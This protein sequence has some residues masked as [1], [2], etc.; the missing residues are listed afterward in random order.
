MTNT[1]A[2]SMSAAV[3]PASAAPLLYELQPTRP[4]PSIDKAK[5]VKHVL[6]S[7]RALRIFNRCTHVA[8]K[9]LG[10]SFLS[11]LMLGGA[12]IMIP[13]SS[14]GVV[15]VVLSVLLQLA[16]ICTALLV[17]R[18]DMV[19]LLT[20]TYE[21]WYLTVAN[22]F[23]CTLV[24][25]SL[26]DARWLVIF[27]VGLAFQFVLLIDANGR[28]TKAVIWATSLGALLNMSYVFCSMFGYL[29]NLE[30]LTLFQYKQRKL[31]A[32]EALLNVLGTLW[33]LMVRNAYRKHQ[34]SR[35]TVKT[36]PHTERVTCIMY[37]C[38]HSMR[39]VS[40]STRTLQ[41]CR[42]SPPVPDVAVTSTICSRSPLSRST[43]QLEFAHIQ[44]HFAEANVSSHPWLGS[45][46]RPLA[47][48]NWLSASSASV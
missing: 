23:V 39:P 7:P 36:S 12:S 14:T 8:G 45:C 31:Q 17:L 15:L 48:F 35:T 2:N 18:F 24:S 41:Q 20:K 43:I 9:F 3:R 1:T 40:V 38:Q 11:G 47:G 21:F 16:P 13:S 46:H 22:V 42:S 26:A 25:L 27:C 29:H 30:E 10:L 5:C 34:F 37:R 6:L 32:D 33:V 4:L 44:H 28:S 19:V